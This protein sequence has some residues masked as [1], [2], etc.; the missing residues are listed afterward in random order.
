MGEKTKIMQLPILPT[1]NGAP[2]TENELHE[3]ARKLGVAVRDY[4]R[5]MERLPFCSVEGAKVGQF[6]DELAE[7]ARRLENVQ[8]ALPQQFVYP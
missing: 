4:Q 6:L 3:F 1:L 7:R 2:V 8:L 5:D